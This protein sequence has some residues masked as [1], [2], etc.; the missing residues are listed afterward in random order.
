VLPLQFQGQ[1]SWET[2]GL[3]GDEQVDVVVDKQLK[4]QG[5]ARLIIRRADGGTKEVP[6]TLRLDT[7]I[8]VDYYR[9]GGI[10]PYVLDQLI[11]D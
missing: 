11:A 3:K 7:P 1:D 4:P 6:L 8:E 9:S 5:N 10:L 2:L